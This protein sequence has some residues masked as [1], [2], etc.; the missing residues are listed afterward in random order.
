MLET[1]HKKT[2]NKSQEQKLPDSGKDNKLSLM[3]LS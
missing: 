2:L 1:T 3:M